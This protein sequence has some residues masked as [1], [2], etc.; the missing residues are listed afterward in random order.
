MQTSWDDLI[1][2]LRSWDDL[3]HH[4]GGEWLDV[5]DRA[6]GLLLMHGGDDLE[7]HEPSAGSAAQRRRLHKLGFRRQDGPRWTWVPPE[8]PPQPAP[9][10][11][12]PRTAAV[13]TASLRMQAIERAVSAQALHVLREVYRCRPTDLE[14]QVAVDPDDWWDDEDEDDD[15]PD[16]DCAAL[17]ALFG[18]QGGRAT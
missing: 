7:L 13:W 8:P 4:L 16:L 12:S 10:S 2:D 5:H 15:L 1:D 18:G 3:E 17:E 11:F 9:P 6:T 14:V